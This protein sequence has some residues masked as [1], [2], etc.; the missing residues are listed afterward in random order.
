[1]HCCW[2]VGGRQMM[3]FGGD[4]RHQQNCYSFLVIC[5]LFHYR[6]SVSLSWKQFARHVYV[7]VWV[8]FSS[9]INVGWNDESWMSLSW[10]W[11][12]VISNFVLCLPLKLNYRNERNKC[13]HCFWHTEL[14]LLHYS[15]CQFCRNSVSL[16]LLYS[17]CIK[18]KCLTSRG[19]M[20]QTLTHTYL[21]TPNHFLILLG[22]PKKN[23]IRCLRKEI[24]DAV[25]STPSPPLFFWNFI[26]ISLDPLFFLS[27]FPYRLFLRMLPPYCSA[28]A[29]AI[30]DDIVYLI[31]HCCW[32]LL[33]N[34]VF[35]YNN[36]Y[37]MI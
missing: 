28:A 21:P 29:A 9:E 11:F 24:W 25:S 3:V 17:C 31:W 16:K 2:M 30:F 27:Q 26:K 12:S 13:C 33:Y 14:L 19:C 18:V 1:M 32:R 34:W 7:W 8:Q 23:E 15:G 10:R 4:N 37:W 22:A 6:I 20:N 5:S 35:D 36:I